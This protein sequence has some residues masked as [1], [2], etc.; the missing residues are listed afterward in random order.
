MN[1][2]TPNQSDILSETEL[3]QN[4]IMND[5]ESS[6]GYIADDFESGQSDIAD[7]FES[8]QSDIADDF[9]AGQSDIVDD[10]ES[11]QS[12][13]VDDSES[14]QNNIENEPKLNQP[15]VTNESGLNVPGLKIPP[16]TVAKRMTE[17]HP[18]GIEGWAGLVTPTNYDLQ[19]A[20]AKGLCSEDGFGEKYLYMQA[21]YRKVFE[22]WLLEATTLREFNDQLAK[23]D[24]D[25]GYTP[26]NQ[27]SFYQY[28]STMDLPFI[29]LCSNIPIERLEEGDLTLLQSSIEN[30]KAKVTPELTNMIKRT[31]SDV[32]M[33]NPQKDDDVGC[34]Y[35]IGG[36]PASPNRSIVLGIRDWV[37]DET[38]DFRDFENNAKRDDYM[39]KLAEEMEQTLSGQIKHRVVVKVEY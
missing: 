20:I 37:F 10:S 17:Q 35:S 34:G 7:D 16:L 8:G 13:I 36:G 6:Q 22:C 23:S 39:I 14:S 18:H 25:Y 5:P 12:D 1:S 29:Y 19:L 9:E 38:G 15:N 33:A 24:L 28:Y 32:L 2:S 21:L 3:S 4:N 11:G 30:G 27:Q 31:F 26:E